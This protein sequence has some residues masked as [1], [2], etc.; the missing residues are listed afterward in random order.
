M[1]S[2]HS[3]KGEVGVRELHANLSRY[4]GDV[5]RGKEVLVTKRGRRIARIS[6]VDPA[7]PL[8]E[9]VRRGLASRPTKSSPL[10]ASA[11]KRELASGSVSELV[12][13]QRR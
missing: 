4:L 9:M 3:N 11:M 1:M 10:K 2:R 7:D 12:A 8:E 6:P 5:S 13:D